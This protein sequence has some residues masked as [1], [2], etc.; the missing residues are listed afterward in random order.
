MDFRGCFLSTDRE[1]MN[2]FPPRARVPLEKNMKDD[3]GFD[4]Y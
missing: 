3:L 4:S 1:Q 2:L